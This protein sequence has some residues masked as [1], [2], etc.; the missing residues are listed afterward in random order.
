MYKS[1]VK[2]PCSAHN[3]QQ[4]HSISLSLP[5]SLG[6]PL[7]L[8]VS[9]STLSASV[10]LCL[11]VNSICLYLSLSPHQLCLP[12]VLVCYSV[13]FVVPVCCTAV[14]VCER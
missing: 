14:R 8:S 5:A 13:L 10:S 6:L 12:R 7:S 1:I 2:Y 4:T 11:P 3:T 9:P